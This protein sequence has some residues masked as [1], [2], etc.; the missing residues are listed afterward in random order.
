ML[1]QVTC[2]YRKRSRS[3]KGQGTLIMSSTNIQPVIFGQ[4]VWWLVIHTTFSLCLCCAQWDGP[5]FCF[6]SQR[7]V[8]LRP[9]QGVSFLCDSCPASH[10]VFSKRIL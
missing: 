3:S 4:F 5:M 7:T 2:Y 1:V 9:K 6:I 8:N 10:C